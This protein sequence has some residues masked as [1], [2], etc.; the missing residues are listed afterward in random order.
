[1]R[2]T[3]PQQKSRAPDMTPRTQR[4]KATTTEE[5]GRSDGGAAGS[6]LSAQL[7]SFYISKFELTILPSSNIQYVHTGKWS[8][9]RTSILYEVVKRSS[10]LHLGFKLDY[11]A[12]IHCG[13]FQL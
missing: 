12:F 6:A 11:G 8:T 1:M 4:P 2:L 13:Y 10:Y 3:D 9:V 7:L 5:Y